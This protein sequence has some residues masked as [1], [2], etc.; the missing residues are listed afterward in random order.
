[1]YAAE[2]VAV[3]AEN[4][5]SVMAK[6]RALQGNMRGL[7][8]HVLADEQPSSSDWSPLRAV[9]SRT[10][11]RAG[12]TMVPLPDLAAVGWRVLPCP[13]YSEVVAGH[14]SL[15]W[16]GRRW[17]V[18]PPEGSPERARTFDGRG[19]AQQWA[20]DRYRAERNGSA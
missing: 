13:N 15:W 19:R 5:A 12:T 14:P 16:G 18:V 3:I 9:P 20:S 8:G 7:I 1:M 2:T 17:A 10:G 6:M 11:G 4:A